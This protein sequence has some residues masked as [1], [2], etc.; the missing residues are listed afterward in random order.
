MRGVILSALLIAAP[1]AALNE[2]LQCVPYARALSGVTIFGDAHTWWGQADGR[3]ERGNEPKVGAVLAFIPH[4]NMRLGHVAA[5]RRVVDDRTLI[6]SHA[7]WSTIGGVRGHIEEDVRA[8]DVS[9]DNDWTRVRVW[10]TP[11]EALGSTEWP[12]HGFIY[13]KQKRSDGEAKRAVAMLLKDRVFPSVPSAAP[14]RM[15]EAKPARAG[16]GLSGDLL[17][18]IDRKAAKESKPTFAPSRATRLASIERLIAKLP[19]S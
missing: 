14:V 6:I 8:V 11:N 5:V 17:K 7:N 15:A 3:Y 9:E 10:Y 2:G 13:P 19:K 4:G 16:F 12:V 1:A 18:D